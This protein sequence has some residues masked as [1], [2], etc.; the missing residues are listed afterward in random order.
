MTGKHDV[1]PASASRTHTWLS[2][3]RAGL[4]L[5]ALYVIV[6]LGYIVTTPVFEKPDENQHFFF[7]LR[8][9][10]GEGLPVQNR[11]PLDVP[12]GQEGSQ[13][14]LYYWLAATLMRPFASAIPETP[15]ARNPHAAIGV[16][17]L[18]ANK[19]AF[20]HP[21][22]SPLSTPLG[23]AV[24]LTRGFSL[25]L[26]A[27]VVWGTWR[28]GI[29]LLPGR[30]D[31][32]LAAAAWL[33]FTPQFLFIASSVSNDV[34]AAALATLVLVVTVKSMGSTASPALVGA[35]GVLAGALALAKLNGV[36]LVPLA[37]VALIIVH[38]ARAGRSPGEARPVAVAAAL[39][40]G[41][42]LGAGWWYW[43]NWALYGEPTGISTL[44]R[45]VGRYERP[46]SARTLLWHL[47][48]LWLSFW[49]VFGWFNVLAPG[50]W[51][52]AIQVAVVLAG[53][54]GARQII[55][56]VRRRMWR[57]AN[58][59][60]LM[61]WALVLV[62]PLV[63]FAGVVQWTRITFGAQG[64]LLFPALASIFIVLAVG[65]AAW[66]PRSLYARLIG[67]ALVA[68]GL[69]AAW[70]PWGV[71][72]PAY[73]LPPRGAEVT[74]PDDLVRLEWTY[75]PLELVGY[76]ISPERVGP[77]EPF[78]IALYWRA[79][80]RVETPYSVSVKVFGYE[81]QLLA[82]DEGYPGRGN[83]PTSFWKPG[84]LVVDARRLWITDRADVPVTADV[85]VDIYQYEGLQTLPPQD[86]GG[87]PLPVPKVGRLSVA[88][89]PLAPAM[90][91]RRIAQF[92]EGIALVSAGSAPRAVRAGEAATVFLTWLA[93]ATPPKDYTVFLH[94]VPAGRQT[95]PVAQTDAPP[96]Q[97]AMPTSAW[98][99]GDLVPDTYGLRLP[100]D[101]PAGMYDLLVGLYEPPAGPRLAVLESLA[102]G[103]PDA[104]LVL[105]LAYDGTV[106]RAVR[107]GEP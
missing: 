96:R 100:A 68:W 69:F 16:P 45:F 58:L 61:A 28:L 14:P 71:I 44:L 4:L 46:P 21:P 2:G 19:N 41:V 31:V 7:A 1:P 77:G 66:V 94:V 101:V 103:W 88:H 107:G 82:Q 57:Q 80:E 83:Y 49:G 48:G 17:T 23:R 32:A 53:L 76:T 34:A 27:L 36:L 90:W 51:Y 24:Y 91:P 29:L 64:R 52:R 13:A 63:V 67:P 60:T 85:W 39:V 105:R 43:R 74:L 18:P 72:R 22:A 3:P 97:N 30:P 50:W 38:R 20:T 93:T 73:A 9:A 98:R 33:A 10:R 104:V 47:S 84:E 15:P 79:R 87:N 25:L 65:L 59:P 75:G 40:I 26:G 106:W 54:G 55:A 92:E 102:G 62:W 8:L 99:P 95:A 81:G 89:R 70:V 56:G 35:A 78:D 86:K 37:G 42:V 5:A 12:W 6:G 11:V